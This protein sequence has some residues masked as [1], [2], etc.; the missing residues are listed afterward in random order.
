MYNNEFKA[1]GAIPTAAMYFKTLY[2]IS[3]KDRAEHGLRV[4]KKNL[5]MLDNI[6]AEILED[7]HQSWGRTETK[8]KK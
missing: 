6:F 3:P 5:G 1:T 8:S 7:I 2:D 4:D